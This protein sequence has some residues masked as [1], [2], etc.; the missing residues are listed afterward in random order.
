MKRSRRSWLKR[1]QILHSAWNFRFL[2][3]NAKNQNIS[4]RGEKNI[5]FPFKV[6]I[7]LRCKCTTNVYM[8]NN[9][10][11]WVLLIEIYTIVEKVNL[12]KTGFRQVDQNF[13]HPVRHKMKFLKIFFRI[14]I[15][16]NFFI[17]SKSHS[18]N[19]YLCQF[20][21]IISDAEGSYGNF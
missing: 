16:F 11:V 17:Y 14:L 12:S 3:K 9:N 6:N 15:F 13:S 2:A 10:W 5:N 18:Q 4:Q 7:F 21:F 1:A 19:T 8:V 20:W